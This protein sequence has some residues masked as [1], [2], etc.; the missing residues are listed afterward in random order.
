MGVLRRLAVGNSFIWDLNFI[1]LT[2]FGQIP[3]LVEGRPTQVFGVSNA[4]SIVYVPANA[5]S[6]VVVNGQPIGPHPAYAFITGYD[7]F[8]LGDPKHD[9]SMGPISAYNYYFSDPATGQPYDVPLAAGGNIGIIRNPLGDF[10]NPETQPR[11]VA[12]TTPIINS[13][14]EG[15]SVSTV[16]NPQT[17]KVVGGFLMA[18]YQT[19]NRVFIYNASQMVYDIEKEAKGTPIPSFSQI[20]E[21][22]VI[23]DDLSHLLRGGLSSVPIDVVYQDVNVRSVFGYFTD[24]ATHKLTYGA[25]YPAVAPLLLG[26]LPRGLASSPVLSGGSLALAPT[27]YNET[28]TID[29]YPNEPLS[30]VTGTGTTADPLTG[31]VQAVESLVGYF[32]LGQQNR[33]SLNY[34]SLNAQDNAIYYFAIA[35]LPPG[36]AGKTLVVRLTVRDDQGNVVA[37]DGLSASDA[38][39]LGLSGGEIFFTLPANIPQGQTFGAGI[40]IDLSKLPTGLYTAQL[41]YGLFTKDPSGKYTNGRF[42][43]Y[44]EPY[45]VVNRS[46]GIFGA[47]WGLT[48]ALELF[49][50]D[51][52]VLLTNGSGQ[53]EIFLAPANVGDPFTSLSVADSSELYQ[54]DDG[55]FELD[56]NG[57]TVDVFDAKGKLSTVTD[58]NGNAVTYKW[59]GDK[60]LS[61][62]DGVGL[63][64]QFQYSGDLV[65]SI[66]EPDTSVVT[67]LKYDG[68]GN[69]I[70]ITNPDGAKTTFQY[71]NPDFKHLLTGQ[72]L[73]RGNDPAETSG[74]NFKETLKYDAFGRLIGGTRADGKSFTLKASQSLAVVDL[75]NGQGSDPTKPYTLV[76][77]ST[78]DGNE[79]KYFATAT[80][81][82]FDG[83]T[84]TYTVTGFGQFHSS[85][86]SADGT[87][88]KSKR[89]DAGLVKTIT[90]PAPAT[91][92]A[93][94]YDDFGNLL[95]QTDFPNGSPVT[96]T[97]T[98]NV[99]LGIPTGHTDSVGRTWTYTLDGNGNVVSTTITDAHAPPGSP[100]TTTTTATYYPN[101][102]IHTSTD[103]DGN[104][105][106]FNYDSYGRLTST[107]YADG[108]TYTIGFDSLAGNPTTFVDETGVRTTMTYNK[109]NQQLTKTV[110]AAGSPA[111]N[112]VWQNAYDAAGNLIKTI[113]S[114]GSV[115]LFSYDGVN[116]ITKQVIDADGVKLTSNYGYT[117]GSLPT[118]YT[119][120]KNSTYTY[121]YTQ[122][123]DGNTAVSVYDNRGLKLYSFDPTGEE[124]QFIYNNN[125]QLTTT[126]LPNGAKIDMHY[127]PRGRQIDQT[128]PT[129]E[130]VT[131]VY[132]NANR[133]VSMTRS[134]NA[135][136]GGD[137]V[138]TY[139]YNLF[140][141]P[142][143]TTDAIGTVTTNTYDAA[144]NV[145]TTTAGSGTPDAFVVT[146]QYDSRNRPI[147][148]TYG[149]V[150]TIHTTYDVAGR[151]ATVSDP[152]DASWITTYKYDALG[153][154]ISSTDAAG[155][156][157][158]SLYDGEGNL[159]STT[160]ALGKVTTYTYD[161]A[162]RMKTMRDAL[163]DLTTYV[164]N[165]NGLA[166][167]VI[168]PRGGITLSTL[169]ADGHLLEIDRPDGR[170]F[171][172]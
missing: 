5:F 160:D 115:S 6:D 166:T 133:V 53:E 114:N 63:V 141:A 75:A 85:L 65:T 128:G 92:S 9:P 64:T 30:V 47:G 151:V 42:F 12:A 156:V 25:P 137:Q 127:D 94:T 109:M 66:V 82:S 61:I 19:L 124:T 31:S 139:Q 172:V 113:D 84:I 72:T 58:R 93:Y 39:A 91:S 99:A 164:R 103:A 36:S 27:P 69:L 104:M 157:R 24:P 13:F 26:R 152:R 105:T 125:R 37:A 123:P 20:G 88:V 89:T 8:V 117:Y 10:L 2:S 18:G 33:T 168:D 118:P 29:S 59:S 49:A 41:D 73:A 87:E 108:A 96:Q 150:S 46:E 126:I 158:S 153:R 121:E 83:D 101:G 167:Q 16:V 120:P 131:Y 17:Q 135:A 97:W 34:V 110:A 95:S 90:R 98:Y 130:K 45:A 171:N 7:K 154:A 51:N 80:Y 144:G 143:V 163:G 112:W 71:G 86:D 50:G 165:G 67:T 55:T 57:G 43:T 22:S 134:N 155:N 146:Y 140:D 21:S 169:D 148:T 116:R 136:D 129:N 54:R 122:D 145:L 23:P 70:S 4:D 44:S 60:L 162:N 11:L 77:L 102:Q 52:G 147:T 132:D 14:P 107:L 76:A 119:V 170:H 3:R 161:G 15:I 79:N 100:S 56:L 1:N 28:P 81:T 149:G 78:L 74:I 40:P 68:N 35:G 32:S 38:S 106:T 111:G 62:T 48:G 138:T 159:L 142:A